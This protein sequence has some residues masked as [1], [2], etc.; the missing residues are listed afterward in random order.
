MDRHSHRK[1][2]TPTQK[3]IQQAALRLF[4]EKGVDRVNLKELAQRAHVARGTI[5]N[6]KRASTEQIFQEIAS[7]VT[8]EMHQ[9]VVATLAEIDDPAQRLSLGIRLFIRRAHEE[10]EWGAFV[11]RFGMNNSLLRQLWYGQPRKDISAG[12]AKR[13]YKLTPE[14]LP[15][16]ITMIA[17]S[18]LGA[19]FLV[20][21]GTR[22]WRKA[23][24]D[25]AELLLRALGI[26]AREALRIATAEL[27]PLAPVVQS[28]PA[29]KSF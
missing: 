25:C 3:R 15:S 27:P 1:S 18:A 22:S 9:R 26:P 4:T 21:Q 13:R 12:I 20:Q 28:D 5:Y 2:L 24:S 14:Q 6:N 8:A 10:P 11:V 29:T 17:T 19:M 7:Q 23:G 16:A